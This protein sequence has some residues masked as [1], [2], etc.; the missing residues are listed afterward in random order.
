MQDITFGST[1]VF[2][3]GNWRFRLPVPALVPS[4]RTPIGFASLFATNGAKAVA[5]LVTV[6]GS[7]DLIIFTSSAAAGATASG[8]PVDGEHPFTWAAGDRL[9][10]TFTYET[11]A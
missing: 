8:G 11:A 5:G 2:G 1:T 6:D 4:T 7:N 3:T 10:A 9:T